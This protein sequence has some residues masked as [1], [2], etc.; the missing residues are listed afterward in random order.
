MNPC[1]EC[2]AERD[3]RWCGECIQPLCL[4][5]LLKHGK[6]HEAEKGEQRDEKG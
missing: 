1:V 6:I 3:G 5:C 4:Q 2:G